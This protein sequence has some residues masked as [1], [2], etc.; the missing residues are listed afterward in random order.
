[1]FLWWSSKDKGKKNI[2]S[3]TFN[4]SSSKIVRWT[5]VVYMQRYI[6]M[7]KLTSWNSFSSSVIS[8]SLSSAGG[9]GLLPENSFF[10]EV[11]S[12]SSLS[13]FP[14]SSLS[15]NRQ[16]QGVVF[17]QQSM[18]HL[19]R[20]SLLQSWYMSK[21]KLFTTLDVLSSLTQQHKKCWLF[22]K[23]NHWQ[24]SKPEMGCLQIYSCGVRVAHHLPRLP[25]ALSYQLLPFLHAP[26]PF[27]LAPASSAFLCP[28]FQGP[29]GSTQVVCAFLQHLKVKSK[30]KAG[31]SHTALMLRC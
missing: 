12:S 26:S 6:W 20:Q 21:R 18:H 29:L 13:S 11:F 31:Y 28:S 22:P 14:S 7:A 24:Q 30:V 16:K 8:G 17:N 9:D 3:I 25:H 10:M 23:G 1:M 2:K 15:W 19:G 5:K 27:A 4:K